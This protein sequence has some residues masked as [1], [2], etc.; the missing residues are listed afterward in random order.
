MFVWRRK[1][2]PGTPLRIDK[3][4]SVDGLVAY[5]MLNESGGL[6]ARDA[7]PYGNHGTLVNGPQWV[8]G[9]FGS[10]IDFPG[11][12][13]YVAL[14]Q[15]PTMFEWSLCVWFS[16]DET[17]DSG[18]VGDV[19]I[20]A[21]N[22]VSNPDV[23]IWFGDV[24]NGKLNFFSYVTGANKDDC[25]STTDSWTANKHYNVIITY[26]NA[27]DVKKIY[28][29]GVEEGSTSHNARNMSDS[30]HSLGGDDNGGAP[31]YLL[32]GLIDLAAIYNRALSAAEVKELYATPFIMFQ[33]MDVAM[34]HVVGGQTFYRTPSDSISF[35]DSLAKEVGLSKSDSLT[36]SESVAKTFGLITSDSLTLAEAVANQFGLY[37]SD[38][39]SL[40]ESVTKQVTKVALDSLNLAEAVAKT[41]GLN[42]SDSISFSDSVQAIVI[43]VKS[44]ADS[45]SFSDSVT[46]TIGLH[47]SELLNLAESVAKNMGISITD[48]LSLAESVVAGIVG[49]IARAVVDQL[50][51]SDSAVATLIHG[52]DH[53]ARKDYKDRVAEDI[54]WHEIIEIERK[55][56]EDE[57]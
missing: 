31:Q 56:S 18:S 51:L 22:A 4:W 47:K 45:I 11:T 53:K 20:Y 7:T 15:I 46:K 26:N 27:G 13:E 19:V 44:V 39:I 24:Y 16:L 14:P 3:H 5:W 37:P 12:N 54:E 32:D 6:I 2:P 36:M 43:L 8:G 28:V 17:W 38:A 50:G 41:M 30:Y 25:L 29:N 23:Y 21:A 35:A 33:A 10:A 48:A 40:A 55:E 42:P 57:E 34:W 52:A 49:Q 9:K 1:P